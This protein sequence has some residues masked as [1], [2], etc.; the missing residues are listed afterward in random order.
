MLRYSPKK[1]NDKKKIIIITCNV[2]NVVAKED[3]ELTSSHRHIKI[4]TVPGA[5]IYKNNMK[6]S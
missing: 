1:T 3:P 4:T 6:T 5:T 2:A